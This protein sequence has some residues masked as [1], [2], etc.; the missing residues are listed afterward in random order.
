[1][2]DTIFALSSGA[3]PS[4]VAIIRLSGSLAFEIASSV[5]GKLPLPRQGK[6]LDL[7]EPGSGN[8][9]D[10]G[11]VLV[12]PGPA[13]FTGEDVVEFQCHGSRPVISKLFDTLGGFEHCRMAEAGEFSRRAFENGKLDLTEIEGLSDL[14]AA[15]TEAQRVLALRQSGG[16]LRAL[17]E[18]WRKDLIRSRALIEAELDFSDEEDVPG[19]VSDQVWK[20]VLELSSAIE[21]HLDDDRNGEIVRDGFRI[22]LTGPPN[23]G[24]SSLLNALAKRDVAIVT[25]IAGTTRDAIDVNLDLDGMK[26]TVTDTAGMRQSDDM[27]EQEG[28]RRATLAA[29]QADLVLWL[30]TP[31]E[32]SDSL[33]PDNAIR[34]WTKSDLVQSESING[35]LT[36]NT[37]DDDGLDTL[38][39]FL[40][41][42]LKSV[43]KVN[44]SPV[45]MRQRHRSALE[46]CQKCLKLVVGSS[47]D[48]EIRSEYLR[49]AADHLGMITGRVDVEDLLDVIFSEFCVGK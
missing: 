18:G 33:P 39:D 34:V 7:V 4:G 9:I 20:M 35:T 41:Q 47:D 22:V 23:A 24:K 31:G 30:Q 36:I 6:L 40:H 14:I 13:S 21:K 3:V 29:D 2:T 37:M 48:I 46:D 25:P 5:V 12:F 38:M 10:R 8:L 44:E 42:Q 26:V 19:G 11:L 17:Y 28:I 45:V 16:Q 49:Q 15:E 32:P 43:S 27:V 1:M